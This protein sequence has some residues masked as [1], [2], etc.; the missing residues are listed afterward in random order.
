M[1]GLLMGR[2]WKTEMEECTLVVMM[3]FYDDASVDSDVDSMS[4]RVRFDGIRV[5]IICLQF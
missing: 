2:R 4:L 5:N 1:L 3:F